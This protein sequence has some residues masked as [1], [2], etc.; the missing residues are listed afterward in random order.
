MSAANLLEP[1]LSIHGSSS[2]HG[3]LRSDPQDYFS[4]SPHQASSPVTELFASSIAECASKLSASSS[5]SHILTLS[6]TV[7]RK[8]Y[9]TI[10][11]LTTEPVTHLLIPSVQE[12]GLV[13]FLQAELPKLASSLMYV[14]PP[15]L[16][17]SLPVMLT[18]FFM[19]FCFFLLWQCAQCQQLRSHVTARG[20]IVV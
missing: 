6:W 1:P 14:P 4:T 10:S 18:E 19:P 17:R 13:A 5:A 16:A 7:S 15:A 3:F 9:L 2:P 12:T 11:S 20:F 8:L